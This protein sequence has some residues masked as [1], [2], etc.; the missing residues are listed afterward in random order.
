M[1]AP[2]PIVELAGGHRIGVEALSRFPEAWHEAPD[3]VLTQAHSV[4]LGDE[5]ELL[6]LGRAAAALDDVTGYVAM[7][8]SAATLPTSRVRRSSVVPRSPD[9]AGAVRA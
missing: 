4:G 7:N 6:A 1:I 3:A 5:L 9:R 2:Q 8:V